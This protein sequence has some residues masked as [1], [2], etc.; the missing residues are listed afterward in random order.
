MHQRDAVAALRSGIIKMSKRL[1]PKGEAYKKFQAQMDNAQDA[2]TAQAD[3]R[4]LR[5]WEY[6][7]TSMAERARR[8]ALSHHTDGRVCEHIVASSLQLLKPSAVP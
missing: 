7:V 3:N 5:S 4:L 6:C 2:Y 8:H 1:A